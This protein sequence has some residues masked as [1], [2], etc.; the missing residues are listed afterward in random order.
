MTPFQLIIKPKNLGYKGNTRKLDRTTFDYCLRICIDS[1]FRQDLYSH[2][3]GSLRS[4]F[5]LFE[6]FEGI[7]QRS[8]GSNTLCSD[9]FLRFDCFRILIAQI[10]AEIYI[11][12]EAWTITFKQFKDFCK[13]LIIFYTFVLLDHF[14]NFYWLILQTECNQYISNSIVNSIKKDLQVISVFTLGWEFINI[15]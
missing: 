1:F 8:K 3:F 4:Y 9:S 2:E 7:Y 13:F 14:S 5:F 12:V 6:W 15:I 11:S 10:V